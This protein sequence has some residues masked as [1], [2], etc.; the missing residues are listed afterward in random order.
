MGH[1]STIVI[2]GGIVGLATAVSLAK[3]GLFVTVLEAEK[4]LGEHQTGRNSGVIHSGIYYKPGSYK[5]RLCLAGREAMFEFAERHQLPVERCGKVIVAT[6]ERDLPGL[7]ELERRGNANGVRSRRLSP[8]QLREREPHVAALAALE[9]FDTGIIRYTDVLEAL[10]KELVRLGGSVLFDSRVSAAVRSGN[11]WIVT[12]RNSE[13]RGVNVITAAGAQSDRVAKLFGTR[14]ETQIIPFRGE[15]YDLKPDR[16]HLCKHLIYPVPDARFPFLGVHA[17]R[18]VDGSVEC[19]PNAVL[20]MS[21]VGYRR[22]LSWSD[23]R[24]SWAFAGTWKIA[25]R[26]WRVGAYEVARSM[27]KSMFVRSMQRLIPELTADD[28]EPGRA[29]IRAQALRRDGTLLDDFEIVAEPNV[30]HVINAPSPAATASLAIGEH[31]A[32]EALRVFG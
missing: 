16:R 29:G 18:G 14:L 22:E 3:R 30:L 11:E 13:V 28:L 4:R 27:F 24:E 20:S 7:D 2:G 9:V 32:D 15:Y 19:G 10:R 31:I 25:M 12:T 6:E 1:S 8:D 17:T 26:Y 5:A 21:R 23:A